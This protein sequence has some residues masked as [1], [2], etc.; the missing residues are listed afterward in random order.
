MDTEKKYTGSKDD[1]IHN[2]QFSGSL[3][4]DHLQ[5]KE[6]ELWE[7]CLA[8][9]GRNVTTLIKKDVFN[10]FEIN[11]VNTYALCPPRKIQRVELAKIAPEITES[12]RDSHNACRDK[13]YLMY[14]CFLQ[15]NYL[16][17]SVLLNALIRNLA[18][19]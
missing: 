19:I 14:K 1:E 12:E 8:P 16:I 13:R 11:P 7:E 2:L 5:G 15:T 9:C 6:M 18:A 10:P 17:C 4:L 3:T